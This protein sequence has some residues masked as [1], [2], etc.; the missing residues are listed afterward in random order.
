MVSNFFIL[1]FAGVVGKENTEIIQTQ[2]PS[3]MITRSKAISVRL[4]RPPNFES[5]KTKKRVAFFLKMWYVL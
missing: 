4:Y 5:L 3:R 2:L 1:N